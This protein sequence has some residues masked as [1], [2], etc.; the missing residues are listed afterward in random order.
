V[1]RV[2]DTATVTE[3]TAAMAADR[4]TRIRTDDPAEAGKVPLAETL[5]GVVAL[6]TT[7]VTTP[8]VHA[9]VLSFHVP[10]TQA[11]TVAVPTMRPPRVMVY[12]APVRAS[13]PVLLTDRYCGAGGESTE[14]GKLTVAGDAAAFHVPDV[15]VCVLGAVPATEPKASPLKPAHATR[16]ATDVAVALLV[17]VLQGTA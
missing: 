17:H 6:V 15:T 1:V 14:M 5:A 3:D 2:T 12:V 10:P 9:F 16:R 8:P 4:L 7:V 11:S 13:V